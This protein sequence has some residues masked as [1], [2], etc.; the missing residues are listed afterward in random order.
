MTKAEDVRKIRI[1]QVSEIMCVVFDKGENVIKENLISH[2]MCE[3]GAS[4]RSVIEYISA[5]KFLIKF[6]EENGLYIK[7][8][9]MAS[10]LQ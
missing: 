3:Y 8:P 9:D 6:K 7:A 1:K 4:R 10:D 5:A 2:L